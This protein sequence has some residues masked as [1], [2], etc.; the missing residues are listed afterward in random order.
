MTRIYYLIFLALSVQGHSQNQLDS[1][2]NYLATL[3]SVFKAVIAD[4]MLKHASFGYVVKDLDSGIHIYGYD[5]ERALT[6]ASTMK[7]VTT[8]G[9]LNILGS[10]YRCT[11]S[12]EYSGKVENRILHGNIFI[13]GGGDPTLG[14]KYFSRANPSYLT[15]WSSAVKNLGIDSITGSVIGDAQF[16]SESMIPSNWAWGDIG[17][18]YGAAA[19]GLSCYDNSL[20]FEFRSGKNAGDSTEIIG[21][22]PDFPDLKI[23]NQVL[24][25]NT[26]VDLAYIYGGPFEQ[27][28]YIR[29]TIP[30][31]RKSFKVKGANP[32]PAYLFAI[33]LQHELLKK[34]I[35]IKGSPTTIRKI[36]ERNSQS[37]Y[38]ADLSKINLPND[39]ISDSIT[40]QV[41]KTIAGVKSPSLS[42]I[43]FW[44]NLISNNLFA[45]HLVRLIGKHKQDVGSVTAG[46]SCIKNFWLSK[47]IDLGG[48]CMSD[49]SGLSRSNKIT[50][51]QL[52]EILSVMDTCSK[53]KSFYSSLP[54]AGK[55]GTIRGMCKGSAAEGN[56]RAKS[57]YMSGVRSYAGYVTTLS[58]RRLAFAMI[59]NNYSCTP[60][61]MKRKMESLM[62]KMAELNY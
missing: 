6:P 16:F 3:D 61:D 29:G 28:R 52:V 40:V 12:L 21:V 34:N 35:A 1:S 27:K 26:K 22:V 58:G 49:G 14:S 11:T 5:T 50:A 18:Y 20:T 30:K 31:A 15:H 53:S 17:N 33:Q 48:M 4:S 39:S 56:L 62:V 38:L 46:T 51:S 45:E 23:V 32:D 44:T 54:E 13:K 42:Q 19:C 47:G 36:R 41:R 2:R 55:T 43:V 57:G 8:G 7:L 60:A 24:A 25:G 37:N 59:A 9:A 10:L